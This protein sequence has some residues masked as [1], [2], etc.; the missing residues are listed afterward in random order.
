MRR[1]ALLLAAGALAQAP[2]GAARSACENPLFNC[3]WH[4]RSE[5]SAA[6]SELP[7]VREDLQYCRHYNHNHASCCNPEV[8]REV[9]V[10]AFRA[11]RLWLGQTLGALE[12]A[13]R[14]LGHLGLGQLGAL[15]QAS[16]RDIAHVD[17]LLIGLGGLINK[18]PEC[19]SAVLEYVAGVLCFSCRADWERFGVVPN[20]TN[21]GKEQ[22]NFLVRVREMDDD[23]VWARCRPFGERAA[24]FMEEM[25]EVKVEIP[26]LAPEVERNITGRL[27]LF[28]S[29]SIL[30]EGLYDGV[31]T[32]P[33]FRGG[34]ASASRKD[35][36]AQGPPA[37]A[38]SERAPSSLPPALPSPVLELGVVE[39]GRLSGFAVRWPR[40]ET[41]KM[42]A[43]LAEDSF[44]EAA[45]AP[46]RDAAGRPAGR[47][48]ELRSAPTWRARGGWLLPWVPAVLLAV[49]APSVHRAAQGFRTACQD[50]HILPSHAEL[51]TERGLAEEVQGLLAV[52]PA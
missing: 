3:I 42:E 45:E 4:S 39:E 48:K 35:P 10:P 46:P 7:E 21:I 50:V 17:A 30:R 38:A 11:W 27:G 14:E 24:A 1:L 13:K 43:K 8:E 34:F 32:R 25:H 15:Q 51:L 2:L 29:R 6:L 9:L 5:A 44:L 19:F 26:L 16:E 37:P 33:M 12:R 52:E 36:S 41:T 20:R 47:L 40:M 18:M 31:A 49:A 23:S 22:P 28:V